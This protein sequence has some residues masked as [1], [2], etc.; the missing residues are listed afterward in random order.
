MDL[1]LATGNLKLGGA[2]REI[3]VLFADV[4]GFTELTDKNQDL[5]DDLV[6]RKK[7]AGDAAE[8]ARDQQ[9]QETLNTVNVYLGLV[10]DTILKQDATL[11]KFMGDCVMAFWGAPTAQPNHAVACVRAAIEAQRAIEALNETRA[12][13]N[14]SREIEN[15]AR[16]AAGLDQKPLLPLLLLGTGINTGMATAG[17]MGSVE[18]MKN[19]TVFGREVN[20]ASR[21]ETLSGRGRI[22]ISQTTYEHLQRDDPALAA[23]CVLQEPQKVKGFATLVQVYDVP[24]REKQPEPAKT[25][26]PRPAQETESEAVKEP[27]IRHHEAP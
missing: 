15:R 5:V 19:Y 11:D 12:A 4:R 7:L 2:R 3:T 23:A 10:A 26:A 21:L 16:S 13:E 25:A 14:K 17:L 9:A 18:K 1:L 20:L 27:A 24:W 22:F 6:R 8:T